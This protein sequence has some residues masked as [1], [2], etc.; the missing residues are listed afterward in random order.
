MPLYKNEALANLRQGSP[1]KIMEY[2]EFHELAERIADKRV[3]VI[4]SL[5]YFTGARPAELVYLKARDIYQK[6][7]KIWIYY[8]TTLKRG[9]PRRFPILARFAEA[10]AI[11]RYRERILDG[12]ALLFPELARVK[13]PKDYIGYR[14]NKAGVNFPPYYFR[15]NRF[16]IMASKGA[17]IE[18]LKNLKGA[19][20]ISSVEYYLHATEAQVESAT[21]FN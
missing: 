13:Q 4:F 5:L 15:H 17:T 12:E 3:K 20:R 16:T 21:K 9:V 11:M 19:R 18:L 2:K 8:T 1:L 7:P 14:L 10:R 6:G